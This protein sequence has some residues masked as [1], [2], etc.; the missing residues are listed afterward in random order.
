MFIKLFVFCYF[1]DTYLWQLVE[2][3]KVLE[4]YSSMDIIEDIRVWEPSDVVM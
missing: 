4:K 3:Y 1:V 2:F